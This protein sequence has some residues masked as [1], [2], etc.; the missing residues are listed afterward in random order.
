M[1]ILSWLSALACCSAV[2]A[3]AWTL[4]SSLF[5]H[6]A[7]MLFFHA[8]LNSDAGRL[9]EPPSVHDQSPVCG[10]PARKL[11]ANG[12]TAAFRKPALDHSGSRRW[13]EPSRKKWRPTTILRN[14]KAATARRV[15]RICL[16]VDQWS[17]RFNNTQEYPEIKSRN[18]GLAS[19]QPLLGLRPRQQSQFKTLLKPRIPV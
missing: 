11:S 3:T 9:L 6:A 15:E 19:R 10:S 5:F 17:L 12:P 4:C 14:A 16:P 2:N 1:A 18:F 13:L 8:S 7:T